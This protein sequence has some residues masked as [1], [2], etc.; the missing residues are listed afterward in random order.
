MLYQE[1][2]STLSTY[3]YHR[4]RAAPA[5]LV[6]YFLARDLQSLDSFNAV[7]SPSG[8]LNPT[9]RVEGI[10]DRFLEVDN[11]DQWEAVISITITL[12]DDRQTDVSKQV[13]VQQSFTS[14]KP[15]KDKHPLAVSKAMAEAMADISTQV[16]KIL[17]ETLQ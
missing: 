12:I 10:L 13:L 1:K 7:I 14:T 5:D 16:N 9:H 4:W 17:V 6:T 2:S 8:R 11:P 3:T 15:S